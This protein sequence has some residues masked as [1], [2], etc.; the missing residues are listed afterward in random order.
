MKG[1]RGVATG[2]ER[3][4][5]AKQSKAK[6]F[7]QSAGRSLYALTLTLPLCRNPNPT[8]LTVTVQGQPCVCLFGTLFLDTPGDSE[9]WEMFGLSC[10]H[11]YTVGTLDM[12]QSCDAC[13]DMGMTYSVIVQCADCVVF[14]SYVSRNNEQLAS[15]SLKLGFKR[16]RLKKV[17]IHCPKNRYTAL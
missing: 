14:P 9:L 15:V 5:K 12:L 3:L 2:G 11:D 1:K 7:S 4:H 10:G 8:K 6:S 13:A 17:F 16:V